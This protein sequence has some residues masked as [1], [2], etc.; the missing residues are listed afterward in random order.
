MTQLPAVTAL[1]LLLPTL[2]R[3]CD[4]ATDAKN[5]TA[6]PIPATVSTT[7]TFVSTPNVNNSVAE[8]TTGTS[9]HGAASTSSAGLLPVTPSTAGGGAESTTGGRP[10]QNESV[11]PEETMTSSSL[12][13]V[14][15]TLQSSQNMTVN[16]SSTETTKIPVS[17]QQQD[18]AP[19]EATVVPS[20]QTTSENV[21]HSQD[22]EDAK[23][24]SSFSTSPSYSSIILP[25]VIVLIVITLSVFVLVGL[26]QMCWKKEP[27]T[28]EDGSDQPQS[29]K[30][31]VK[32]LTVKTISHEPGEHRVAEKSKN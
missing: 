13:S 31:S 30:E 3:E 15:P 20:T 8:P 17:T 10:S 26:Y 25:V 28:P 32:L 23:N 4:C 24:T 11:T 21:S 19:S 29:N 7:N 18:P 12:S 5:I 22:I 1:L 6:S 14:P 2:C 9:S 27:G 16:Q